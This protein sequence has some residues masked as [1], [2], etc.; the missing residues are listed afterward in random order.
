MSWATDRAEAMGAVGA[1]RFCGEGYCCD[2]D[3]S[4]DGVVAWHYSDR[5]RTF[6]GRA[7][8]AEEAPEVAADGASES[9]DG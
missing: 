8:T 1:P 7:N 6:A 4:G 9:T 2:A 5:D 3:H